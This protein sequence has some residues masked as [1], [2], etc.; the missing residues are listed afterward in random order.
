VDTAVEV[1]G[2]AAG[3]ELATNI[4]RERQA[5][6]LL[7]SVYRREPFDIGNQIMCKAP[8]LYGAHPVYSEDPLE[9][10]RRGIWGFSE[11]ILPV[12]RFIT[13]RFG[14]DEIQD[15]M[16]LAYSRTGTGGYIKGII[17]PEEG[18]E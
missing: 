4:V 6:I 14:L 1:T 18:I 15:A 16:E 8:V 12:K 5:K 17:M 3:L 2:R 7:A 9:D 13:H 10:A 11:G